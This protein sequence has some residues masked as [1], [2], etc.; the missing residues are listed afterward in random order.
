M[1]ESCKRSNL[2]H[3][4]PSGDGESL[5]QTFDIAL[6]DEVAHNALIE[7]L[8]ALEHVSEVVLIASK[9]DVDY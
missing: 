1:K 3:I 8:D 5:T 9:N 6:R 7:S 4:E 2:L